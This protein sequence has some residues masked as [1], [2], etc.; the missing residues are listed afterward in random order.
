MEWNWI[1][2]KLLPLIETREKAL[3]FFWKKISQTHRTTHFP[4]SNRKLFARLFAFVSCDKK[5][6]YTRSKDKN[7]HFLSN[8]NRTT[9]FIFLFPSPR[10]R[11][12]RRSSSKKLF[13]KCICVHLMIHNIKGNER[14]LLFSNKNRYR[15]LLSI[16]HPSHDE[17]KTARNGNRKAWKGGERDRNS[18]IETKW[19]FSSSIATG[20]GNGHSDFASKTKS[21][22]NGRGKSVHSHHRPKQ[23]ATK[24]RRKSKILGF[25][26]RPHIVFNFTIENLFSIFQLICM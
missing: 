10:P 21:I 18:T 23:T 15:A 25:S 19:K 9:I 1:W 7:N 20:L 3:V 4:F 2:L 17:R 6:L 14:R 5:I 11:L 26:A 16:D 24:S 8:V 13:Q 12:A 22:L